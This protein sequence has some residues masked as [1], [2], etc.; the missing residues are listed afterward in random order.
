MRQTDLGGVGGMGATAE[1]AGERLVVGAH[2]DDADDIPVLLAKEGDST[3]GLGLVDTHD[4]GHDRLG[5]EDLL[6]D[7]VLDRLELLGGQ[8]LEVREVKAQVLG[9]H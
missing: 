4:A 7:Q 9:R 2:G 6:V 5:S 1:L 8:S 3:S